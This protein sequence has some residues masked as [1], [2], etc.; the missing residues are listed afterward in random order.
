MASHISRYSLYRELRRHLTLADRRN[1]AFEQNKAAKYILYIAAAFV[2]L[3]LMMF[4]VIL[5]LAANESKWLEA[6]TLM[7]GISPLIL[8]ADFF[9]RFIVQ[10]TPTQLVKPYSLL[11]ISKFACIDCFIANSVLSLGN[12]TWFAMFIPYVIMAVIFSEGVVASLGFLFGFYLLIVINSQWYSL[13]RTLI[14]THIA[15]WALPA[16]VYAVMF[17]PWYIG[18]GAGFERLCDTYAHLGEWLPGWNIL[19]YL[20]LFALLALLIFINRRV[21]YHQIWAE[22][23]KVEQTKIRHASKLAFFNR[24]GE[25][26]EYLKLEAKSIMR[27]K[28]LRKIFIFACIFILIISLIV[29]Y[30]DVYSGEYMTIFWCIYNFAIFGAMILV[31]VMC[32]EGNYIECLMIRKENII[33]LLTAKFYF[34][35]TLLL[36]PFILMIPTLITGKCTLLMLLGVMMFTAGVVHCLFFQM[37]VYNKQ[38]IPL[39]TKLIGK[40][41]M[42]NNYLQ[43]VVEMIVFIVPIILIKV[44]EALFGSTV[45][46]SIIL[47]IGILFILGHPLWIRNIYNRMQK[48]RYENLE[49]FRAS[50]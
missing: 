28:N 43:I 15:W 46:Y 36:I 22:L 17:S 33:S 21:Q 13:A 2:I 5:A 45:A 44:L 35:S 16:V 14:N 3:Y 7:Y 34:Y 20:C 12:L 11:P 23:G 27:N 41:G 32:Y 4:G 26:G 19:A 47:C 9:V 1:V 30:T 37:A 40:G 39:N 31:K 29:S 48:R 42:E 18:K 38:S 8:T 49:G 24:F 6:S 50:R 10:Q 25:T